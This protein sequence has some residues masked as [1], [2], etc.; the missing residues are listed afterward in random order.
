MLDRLTMP[1]GALGEASDLLAPHDC[2]LALG[3]DNMSRLFTYGRLIEETL[4]QKQLEA[5]RYGIQ[6]GLPTGND[7]FKQQIEETLSI[8]LR[9]GKR[10]RPKNITQSINPIS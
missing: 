9:T 5:I 10:G 4:E 6:K 1:T 7:K 8:K 2:W 3:N